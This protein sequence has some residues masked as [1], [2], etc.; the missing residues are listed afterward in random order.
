M[1]EDRFPDQ[2][3][4]LTYFSDR[5]DD[6][7]LL[8][9]MFDGASQQSVVKLIRLT[10]GREL[11]RWRPDVN[12]IQ[13]R[14][15]LQSDYAERNNQR[16]KPYRIIH[17]YLQEGGSILFTLDHLA[18]YHPVVIDSSPDHLDYWLQL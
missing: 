12:E 18:F 16:P 4:G 5:K 13:S 3:Y 10:D 11:H 14:S 1:V 8:L 15:R 2:S 9:S 6:G 7:Y 17:P